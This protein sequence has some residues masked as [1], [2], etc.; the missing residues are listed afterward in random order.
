[1]RQTA[2]DQHI[3]RVARSDDPLRPS[4]GS[5]DDL[6]L[7]DAGNRFDSQRG[8]YGVLYFATDLTCCFGELLAPLR[9]SPKM[10]AY[11]EGD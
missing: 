6:S 2:P 11:I 1:M 4:R 9:P 3:W 5:P 10:L 7:P 8:D